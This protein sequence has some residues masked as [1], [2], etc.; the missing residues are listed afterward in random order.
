LWIHAAANAAAAAEAAG[1]N[2]S[3]VCPREAGK[4]RLLQCSIGALSA[5]GCC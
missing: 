5:E 4:D 3:S 1:V 2:I